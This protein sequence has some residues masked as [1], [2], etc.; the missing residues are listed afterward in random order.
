MDTP[1]ALPSCARVA[2]YDAFAAAMKRYAAACD[3]DD[4]PA[5]REIRAELQDLL[6][7]KTL[8]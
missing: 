8:I 1:A 4:W 7:T 2:Q 6:S 3:A 5:A